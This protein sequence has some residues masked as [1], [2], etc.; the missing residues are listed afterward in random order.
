M[1][2]F[3]MDV[4]R[5]CR[6]SRQGSMATQKNRQ[7]GL[8]AIAGT[9][10]HLGYKIRSA[11]HLKPK[12]I[13]ALVG[14]WREEG[15]SDNTQ[16]NR[17]SWLRWLTRQTN[18]GNI[19]KRDNSAYNLARQQNREPVNKAQSLDKDRLNTIDCP[20][21]RA[22]VLMQ[23]AFGLRR[24]EALKFQPKIGIRTNK[25]VLKASWTKGKRYREIPITNQAQRQVLNAVRQLAQGGSLIPADKSYAEQLKRHGYLTKKAGLMNLHGLRHAWAQRRYAELAQM[26]CPFQGGKTWLE[27][28]PQERQRDRQ[29]R[30]QLAQ[31]LGHGRSSISALY[32]GRAV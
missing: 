8:T 20:W 3:T 10:R 12:H 26:R 1:D 13:D 22:A 5:L 4:V 11:R 31:E 24:E 29:A 28:T 14:H 9:L 32:I 30:Q 19:I 2:A 27:M 18:R 21:I 17:M 25:I 6:Q 16:R 15:I 7:V 23:A